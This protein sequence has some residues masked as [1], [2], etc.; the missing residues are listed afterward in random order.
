M[1]KFNE[2]YAFIVVGQNVYRVDVNGSFELTGTIQYGTTP[3]YMESNG[4]VIFMATGPKGYVINTAANTVTEYVSPGFNGAG[5]VGFINGSFVFN[6]PN[7][8]K[9][10]GMQPYST[11]LDPLNFFTA[12]GSPD[13]LVT[14]LVDHTEIWL[15]GSETTEVW[16]N[17]GDTA[18]AN[19]RR[20][21]G[22]FFEQG[23]AAAGSV[24][25]MIDS[26]GVGA[27]YWLSSSKNGEGMVFRAVGFQPERISTHAIE[28]AIASYDI[29]SDATAWT[30][31]Q[32]GHSFYVLNFPSANATWV[33][34]STTGM[35]HERAWRQYDGKQGRHRGNCHMF[36]GRRNLVGDWQNGN[37][38]AM[39]LDTYSDDGNPIVRLR[40]SPH[41][42]QGAMV[43]G[44]SSVMFEMETGV[45]IQSGQGE[46]PKAMI[47]WS[48]DGGHTWSSQRES[49]IGKVGSYKSVVRETR[50]GKSH[51]RVYE[52][53]ISDP[54]KVVITGAIINE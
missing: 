50:L 53:S 39:D 46:D 15:F 35:W 3:V 31:Q 22:A 20:I 32:E 24:D 11:T 26:L 48:D 43:I 6:E 40:S 33:F 29:I 27:V 1:K 2:Q 23:C 8:G 12:E 10:W 13:N 44:H 49:S 4:T 21:D 25:Q 5:R 52:L 38:Y 16:Y 51:D 17:T 37:V 14:L 36:F 45:G 28:R 19:Y 41:V 47:R 9:F 54:I 30:Y 18:T 34:D 7:S 42:A